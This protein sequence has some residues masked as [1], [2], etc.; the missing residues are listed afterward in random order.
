MSFGLVFFQTT[1]HTHTQTVWR[2]NKSLGGP[3]TRKF[4]PWV[5]EVCVRSADV[6]LKFLRTLQP[7]IFA[8]HSLLLLSHHPSLH[9]FLQ[10]LFQCL[11]AGAGSCQ[12]NKYINPEKSHSFTET[13][14]ILAQLLPPSLTFAIPNQICMHFSPLRAWLYVVSFGWRARWLALDCGVFSWGRFL[15][16]KEASSS[17]SVTSDLLALSHIG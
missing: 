10:L 13:T 4:F 8:L 1:T 15:R 16:L 2:N 3:Q 5:S 12:K 14:L 9:I 17:W 6:S 11:S 7:D